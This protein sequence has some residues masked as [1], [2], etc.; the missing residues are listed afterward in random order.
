MNNKQI[1]KN[2]PTYRR[3]IKFSNNNVFNSLNR[4]RNLGK[5]KKLDFSSVGNKYFSLEN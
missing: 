1:R 3:N 2:I 4:D 5:F